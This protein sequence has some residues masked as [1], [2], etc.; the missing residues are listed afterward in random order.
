MC[1]MRFRAVSEAGSNVT[2]FYSHCDTRPIIII[3]L[4]R[5][6]PGVMVIMVCM[7]LTETDVLQIHI[8]FLKLLLHPKYIQIP[9]IVYTQI[10]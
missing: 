3:I 4:K 5:P 1:C 9:S 8:G 10:P 6:G 7:G 2:V